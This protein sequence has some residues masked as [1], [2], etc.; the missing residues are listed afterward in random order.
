[1][2]NTIDSQNNYAKTFDEVYNGSLT[3]NGSEYDIVYSY[4]RT[5]SDTNSIAK[6]FT[7]YLFRISN[8]TGISF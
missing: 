8:A 7:E 2:A 5:I 6:N 4:F 3:I 1:M